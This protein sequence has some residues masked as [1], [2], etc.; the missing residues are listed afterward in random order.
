MDILL[1]L[2]VGTILLG[3][4]SLA[5]WSF[6]LRQD[7]IDVSGTKVFNFKEEDRSPDLF[8]SIVTHY[9]CA[10]FIAGIITI[11]FH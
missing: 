7:T 5:A 8:E 6:M 9:G 4:L 3:S 10:L 11:V 2:L 1:N